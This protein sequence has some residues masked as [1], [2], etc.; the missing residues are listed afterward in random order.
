MYEPDGIDNKEVTMNQAP[1]R[2]QLYLSLLQIDHLVAVMAATAPENKMLWQQQ[3]MLR[4]QY[5]TLVTD[6]DALQDISQ[7]QHA[8]QDLETLCDESYRVCGELNGDTASADSIDSVVRSACQATR[9]LAE[10]VS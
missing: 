8:M 9:R 5:T 10:L 2:Q 7:L 4:Q 1:L 6:A 3:A